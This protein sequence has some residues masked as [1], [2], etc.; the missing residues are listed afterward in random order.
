MARSGFLHGAARA[1]GVRIGPRRF[2]LDPRAGTE[3]PRGA[4]AVV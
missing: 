3:M 4:G 1:I 2:A